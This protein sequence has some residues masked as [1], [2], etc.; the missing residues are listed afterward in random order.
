[1][2]LPQIAERVVC[3]DYINYGNFNGVSGELFSLS[4][5][6]KSNKENEKID[7]VVGKKQSLLSFCSKITAKVS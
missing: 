5:L 6:F 1:M 3:V 4:T 7:P 2:G